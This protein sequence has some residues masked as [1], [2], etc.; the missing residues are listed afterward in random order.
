M[1]N[2]GWRHIGIGGDVNCSVFGRISGKI[3]RKPF[4]RHNFIL[5]FSQFRIELIQ[6]VMLVNVSQRPAHAFFTGNGHGGLAV[7]KFHRVHVKDAPE[8]R[9]NILNVWMGLNAGGINELEK[10]TPRS[11]IDTKPVAEYVHHITPVYSGCVFL[12]IF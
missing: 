9:H 10:N 3:P 6:R 5:G 4:F 7:V 1:R 8:Y 2:D 12:A 11:I